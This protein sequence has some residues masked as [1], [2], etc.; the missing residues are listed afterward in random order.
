MRRGFS[1]LEL[2]I[3]LAVLLAM[4]GLVMPAL[5]NSLRA[6]SFEH[7]ADLVA[8][9][10]LL[11]RAHAQRTGKPVEVLWVRERS[12]IE[13]RY[14]S[15]NAN[16]EDR[17]ENFQDEGSDSEFDEEIREPW[18]IQGI[19]SEILFSRQPPDDT[20]ETGDM[21]EEEDIE[22]EYEIRLAVLWPDGSAWPAES[23]WLK[24]EGERAVPVIINPWT[25]EMME[26]QPPEMESEYSEEEDSG[27]LEE[28]R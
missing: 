13:A 8:H 20:G 28:P 23:L 12:W 24:D 1:L 9:Q 17:G 3:A 5:L 22:E 16:K 18:G 10:L 4:G 15:L 21:R 7:A 11:A 19:S 6:R 25:G 26:E 27:D 14:F 2:M